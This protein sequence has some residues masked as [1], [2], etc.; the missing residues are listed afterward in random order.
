MTNSRQSSTGRSA[1][2]RRMCAAGVTVLCG[3][4]AAASAR[5]QLIQ[6][7]VAIQNARILTM[8]GA[9]I[10][11]GTLVIK[12]EKIVALGSDVKPPVLAK[13]V[14]ARGGTLTP[15]LI[16]AYSALGRSSAG[17]GSAT[18][19]AEDAFDH[20][21]TANLVEALR[22]GVTAVY[23]SPGSSPG[24]CGTGAILRLVPAPGRESVGRVLTSEAALCISLGSESRPVAR[25]KTLAAVRKQFQDAL[26]HRQAL[27]GYKEDLAKYEKELKEWVAKQEKKKPKAKEEE[28]G[29]PTGRKPAPKQTAA[30]EPKPK[31][32]PEEKKKEPEKKEDGKPKKPSRPGRK[33]HLD[34]V[35]R[36][37]DREIP[38]RIIAHRSED[39]L[40]ALEL[41]DEFSL[42]PILEGAAEAHLVAKEIAEAKAL[43]MLGDLARNSVRRDDVFRR[44]I[45]DTAGVLSAA[46]AGWVVGSGAENPATARFVAL[47]SQLA[48]ARGGRNDPLLTVTAKA[49]DALRAADQ[50]GRLRPGLLADL[51]LWSA[52]P[53]DP[54][55]KVRQVYVGGVLA[56]EAT[57]QAEK[58]G[59]E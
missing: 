5:A 20:Y 56:F 29:P 12:G 28:K 13:K 3:A 9:V 35:L 40:N 26:D 45:A 27:E 21:D 7:P 15:G 18:R 52:D 57:E 22:N 23:L 4:V 42:D 53:L 58:G 19:R 48:T 43:V 47:N 1:S 24:T 8:D 59:T 31:E 41:A 55:A 36:A 6:R 14:D 33:P 16:D 51:V 50:I 34:V 38:V 17:S 37:L 30:A 11:N 46:G 2:Y 10:E 54:A 32:K 25:L 39:I 49:A 44:G